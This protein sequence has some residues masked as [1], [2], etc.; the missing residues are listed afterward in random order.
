MILII[1]G[2]VFGIMAFIFSRTNKWNYLIA[3]F[4]IILFAMYFDPIVY[5]LF[6]SIGIAT[7]PN[8]EMSIQTNLILLYFA[9]GGIILGKAI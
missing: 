7:P 2:L 4:G 5:S 3:L 1:E 9:I 8:L 6:G